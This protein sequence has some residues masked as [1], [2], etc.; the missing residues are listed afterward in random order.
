MYKENKIKCPECE[1][2]LKLVQ[3]GAYARN[4]SEGEQHKHK[5]QLICID[6]K[7]KNFNQ[8]IEVELD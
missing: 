5:D 4:K 6:E 2:E 7:C 1:K 8:P 3:E